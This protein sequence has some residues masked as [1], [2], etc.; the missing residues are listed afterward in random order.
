VSRLSA[1]CV[2][3]IV[4]SGLSLVSSQYRARQLFIDLE[5]A[6]AIEHKLDIEWRTLQLDQT[7]YSKHS[8]IE[9]AA[10]R[11]LRMQ[12]ATPARTQYIV[13]TDRGDAVKDAPAA[14][15]IDAKGAP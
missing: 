5:S 2:V 13:L 10:R 3:L 4:M 15:P 9:S 14:S 8:L 11:D 7:N 1:L 12:P 6:R